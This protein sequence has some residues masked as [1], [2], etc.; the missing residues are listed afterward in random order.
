MAFTAG[1]RVES[2]RALVFDN[3]RTKLPKGSKGTSLG[4]GRVLTRVD[5]DDDTTARA[6]R[7]VANSDLKCA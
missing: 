1:T 2:R 5:F 6:Y 4:G 7:L 3:G